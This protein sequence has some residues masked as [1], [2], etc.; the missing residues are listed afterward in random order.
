MSRKELKKLYGDLYKL[1]Y[2]EGKRYNCFYC[3]E[4]AE[5]VDHQP[6]LSR[7]ADYQSLGLLFEQYL[8]VPCCPECNSLA[9]KTLTISLLERDELIKDRIEH[10]YKSVLN[11][12]MFWTKRAIR[13]AELKGYLR[14]YVSAHSAEQ[15]RILER[16]DYR[17]G[18]VQYVGHIMEYPTAEREF[19]LRTLL[20]D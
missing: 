10:K 18:V 1:F 7:V 11:T 19:I 16:L 12:G 4:P 15:R 14:D 2:V 8:K 17:E 3:G 5:G 9:G 20:E 13:E 6:P